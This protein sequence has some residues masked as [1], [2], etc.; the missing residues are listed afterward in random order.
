MKG[1]IKVV[2]VTTVMLMLTSCVVHEHY[3]R[4][5][6]PPGHTKK[7]YIYEKRGNGHSHGHHRGRGHHRWN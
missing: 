2:G 3:G 5:G 6:R 7:V 4:R 1:L